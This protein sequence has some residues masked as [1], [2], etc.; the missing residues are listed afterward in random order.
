M[1]QTKKKGFTLIELLVVI[2]IIGV[3]A[4]IGVSALS[5]S[6][7]KARDA[8]R[9]G[10]LHSLTQYL[11]GSYLVQYSVYPIAD[12]NPAGPISGLPAEQG[13]A[14]TGDTS[15]TFSTDM[16]TALAVIPKSPNQAGAGTVNDYW[17]VTNAKGAEFAFFT[18]LE[19]ADAQE[20]F[21]SNSKG[22]ADSITGSEGVTHLPS[23]ANTECV[24]DTPT[25]GYFSPCLSNP[26]IQ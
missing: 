9:K 3:L 19:N 14:W 2:A 13:P 24:D 5:G 1:T 4:A 16:G 20:W 18:K 25:A 8:K 15:K 12:P 23:T 7:S 6:Q 21:V 22:W 10:D 26:Q 17:Y 11:I